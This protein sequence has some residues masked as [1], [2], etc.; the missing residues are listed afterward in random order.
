MKTKLFQAIFLILLS[1]L[2]TSLYAEEI[3]VGISGSEPFRIMD[4][5]EVSGISFDIWKNVASKANL[6]YKV[7]VFDSVGELLAAVKENKVDVGVGSISIT[8]DRSEV[9]AFTQPYYISGKGILTRESS[10]SVWD[11]I[12]PFFQETF[13]YGIASLLLVLFIVGNF[14]WLAE[15]HHNQSVSESYLTGVGSCMWFAIVTFTTVGYGDITPKTKTGRVVTGIWMIVALLTASSLTAG[16][17]SSFTL[18]ELKHALI[19]SPSSLKG[20]KV[21]AIKSTTGA[22]FAKRYG[23]ILTEVKTLKDGVK[24]LKE[25]EVDAVI[26]DYP[27]IKYYLSK[28]EEKGFRAIEVFEEREHY[29][30]CTNPKNPLIRTVNRYILETIEEGTIKN[31]L[32]K[33]KVE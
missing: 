19:D 15:R 33:W 31:I 29:G 28:N 6:Q 32:K 8:A 4:K 2:T 23:A 5:N 3:K 21:A 11:F 10:A 20:R 24:L 9:L 22:E 13:F 17:A 12:K 25:T 14:V 1:F 27:I 16:I 7:T 30:F 18:F 26:S